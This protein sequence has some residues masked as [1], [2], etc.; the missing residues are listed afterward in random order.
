MDEK[1]QFQYDDSKKRLNDL[2]ERHRAAVLYADAKKAE[3][4]DATAEAS[5]LL[6]ELNKENE[7]YMELEKAVE[8][9]NAGN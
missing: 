2:S 5:R 3:W 7:K 4:D 6:L 1:L 9:E 8:A